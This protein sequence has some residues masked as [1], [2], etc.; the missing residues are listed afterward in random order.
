MIDGEIIINAEFDY[1]FAG[2]TFKIKRANLKQVI[3]WQRKVAEI[4]KENDP[5]R[6]ALMVAYALYLSLNAVDTTITED[7]ILDNAPG[8]LDVMGTLAILGFMSQQK[9]EMAQKVRDAL[10]NNPT[11]LIPPTTPLNGPESSV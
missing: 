4:V 7:Y 6:D 9:V 11:E 3:S 8:D 5:S 1:S 10:V 2:K